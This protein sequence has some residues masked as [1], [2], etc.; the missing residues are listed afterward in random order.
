MNTFLSGPETTVA[1]PESQ[2]LRS[3]P[4]AKRRSTWSTFRASFRK[5]TPN[6]KD[7]LAEVGRGAG[8][9]G[10]SAEETGEAAEACA[11]AAGD[12]TQGEGTV[13]NA[14]SGQA[15]GGAEAGAEAAA[16]WSV[17]QC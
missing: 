5:S 14:R 1:A 3:N 11:E 7:L 10:A 15:M 17:K 4:R 16:E 12:T 9:V 6:T 13:G 8:E 2:S